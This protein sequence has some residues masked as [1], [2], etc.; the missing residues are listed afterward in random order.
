[1]I[2]DNNHR[3]QR[4]FYISS[5][6]LVLS[7]VVFRLIAMQQDIISYVDQIQQLKKPSSPVLPKADDEQ[8]E[9]VKKVK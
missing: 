7:I 4:N 1:M 8:D 9:E 6:G 2:M 5:F 3:C